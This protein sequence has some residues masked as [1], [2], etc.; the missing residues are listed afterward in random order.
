MEKPTVEKLL[1]LQQTISGRA[2]LR[3][4]AYNPLHVSPG[5]AERRPTRLGVVTF[6]PKA[7][8]AKRVAGRNNL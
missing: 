6:P 1:A 8:R 4:A 2:R 7:C 3:W 5:S